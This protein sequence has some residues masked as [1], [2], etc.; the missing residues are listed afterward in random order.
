MLIKEVTNMR[1]KLFVVAVLALLVTLVPSAAFAAKPPAVEGIN[2]TEATIT[3]PGMDLLL[4][5]VLYFF[6][7]TF[8][9]VTG[10]YLYNW[11]VGIYLYRPDT[12]GGYTWTF[13]AN[14]FDA[15]D[16]IAYDFESPVRRQTWPTYA[17]SDSHANYY[18]KMMVPRDE[19]WFPCSYP[20]KWKCNVFDPYSGWVEFHSPKALGFTYPYG[21][22][23]A[24]YMTHYPLFWPWDIMWNDPYMGFVNYYG[25]YP[26]YDWY[27][28]DYTVLDASPFDTVHPLWIYAVDDVGKWIMYS[29]ENKVWGYWWRP[30]DLKVGY[31]EEWPFICGDPYE[32]P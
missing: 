10:D 7:V 4:G 25:P 28:Y 18:A 14:F 16:W 27:W 22:D 3:E 29:W 30:S 24:Y 31:P 21:A 6:L 5:D 11:P 15:T 8:D 9:P 17:R 32:W 26:W 20:C 23:S 12:Y 19:A 1:R 13:P 2:A